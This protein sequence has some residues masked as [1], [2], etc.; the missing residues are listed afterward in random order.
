M[1]TETCNDVLEGSKET[2]RLD[3]NR[4]KF[5]DIIIMST[6]IDI[7]FSIDILSVS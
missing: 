6:M 5:S 3:H 7:P 1:L 2:T 4:N